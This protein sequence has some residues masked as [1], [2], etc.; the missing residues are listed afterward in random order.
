MFSSPSKL[1]ND[2]H[3]TESDYLCVFDDAIVE[4]T[5]MRLRDEQTSRVMDSIPTKTYL[6]VTIVHLHESNITWPG[7]RAGD[8][9]FNECKL[10]S[11]VTLHYIQAN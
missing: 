11:I 4:Q 3:E 9:S 8:S 7:G 10:C 5:I 2:F 6:I 1:K